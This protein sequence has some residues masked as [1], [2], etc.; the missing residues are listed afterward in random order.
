MKLTGGRSPLHLAY[1]QNIHPAESWTSH[2]AAIA[3]HTLAVRDQLEIKDP[4][5]LGLRLGVDAAAELEA[6]PALR[7]AARE[8][9]REQNLYAY[10]VNAFPF[11]TF[12]GTRVKE[13][14]Y[15]P[16]WRTSERVDYTL[17]VARVLADLMPTDQPEL[18][19]SISTVPGSFKPW[20]QNAADRKAMARNIRQVAGELH[21]LRESTGREIHLGLE[22]EPCCFMETTEE[23][24]RFYEDDLLAGGRGEEDAIL[25]RH[26]GINF[27]CCH[28]AIQFENL[29]DSLRRIDT[30]GIRISKIHL[31]AALRVWPESVSRLRPFAEGVYLHQVKAKGDEG[32]RS[33]TDLPDFLEEAPSAWNEARVHFHVPLFWEGDTELGTTAASMDADFFQT[34]KELSCPPHLEMETY[35]FDV[36]PEALQSASVEENLVREYQWVLGHL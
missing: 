36:L 10:T 3:K 16:D 2:Q 35:T 12:H 31:S 5:G 8:F 4:F 20:I 25:R 29:A 26:I 34:L 30:A 11:G 27:D 15:A 19:G 7:E 9:F 21:R 17:Q 14:V 23:F 22:P 6:S 24:I 13:Q 1:C 33:W 32:I 18:D 28:Q